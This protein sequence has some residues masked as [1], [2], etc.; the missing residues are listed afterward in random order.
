MALG[1]RANHASGGFSLIMRTNTAPRILA[2]AL[3]LACFPAAGRC[4]VRLPGILSSHMVLQRERPIHIWGWSNPGETVTVEFHGISRSTAGD[5]L[6]NWSVFLP[7]EAAGG[8]HQLTVAGSNKIVLDDVLVGDVWFASGQSN[9]EMPLKGWDGAPVKDSAEEIAH[10]AQ[11]KIRLLYIPHKASDYPLRDSDASWTVCS[12]ETAANFSDAAY[13]F[14]RDL[15]DREHVPIGLIDATWGG[16]VIEAWISLRAISSDA[17]LMPVFATRAAMTDRQSETEAIIAKE[18][19]ED[20]A[21]REAG[22]TPPRHPWHPDPASWAP[23]A[24]FNGMVSP[25]V[26]YTLK[27]VIWYQGESNSGRDFAPMYVKLLPTLIADWRTH[28]HEGNFPFLFVQIS[29]FKSS[30]HESW[31][32][33]REAQ[34]RTL[35]VANT[36]MAVTIDIGNPDNV[37]PADKQTVGARLALAARALAYDEDVEYSGPLFRQAT[38]EDHSLRVWFDHATNGLVAKGGALEG[39]EIAGDDG[40]FATASARIDGKTVV[41][42]SPQVSEPKYVRYGWANAP[43]VNLYNGE[44]LPAS[45]FTSED[46]IPAP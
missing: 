32:T 22:R 31:A 5:S 34:R 12:P 24:L 15:A 14:G 20:Q 39:F 10:A 21:A 18:K 45:P 43:V 35:S 16:T 7:P 40:H 11:P 25:E 19:R 27:G 6:G 13:F 41:V 37:H 1:L 46:V 30:P 8:P 4:E 38:S 33:I 36:A 44:G 29:N 3:L 23:A 26:G 42:S 9:M 2:L 28:W 17:G